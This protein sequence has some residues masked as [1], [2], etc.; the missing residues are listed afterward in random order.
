MR[1]RRR[2]SRNPIKPANPSATKITGATGRSPALWSA[3][4]VAYER[5]ESTDQRDCDD[6]ADPVDAAD[7]IEPIDAKEPTLATDANE[8]TDPIESTDRYDAMD[9][10]ESVDHRDQRF[11]MKAS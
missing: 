9:N 11:A 6:I 3:I 5:D 4:W 1:E 8:P 2:S 7:P 10:T